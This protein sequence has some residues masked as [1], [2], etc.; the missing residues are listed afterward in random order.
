MIGKLSIL[1]LY[2][3]DNTIFDDLALPQHVYVDENDQEQTEDAIDKQT[4]VDNLLMDLAEIS[5][6]IT[7]P[8]VM[9][10]A[11][12]SWSASCLPVWQA[13]WDTTQYEYNPIWNK[14]G[15][16]TEVEERDL[17]KTTDATETRN[18]T[19]SNDVQ[20][21][22]KTSAFNASTMQP[23]DQVITD[24]DTT[25]GGTIDYDNTVTDG[26]QITRT[27]TEQGNIGVTTTQQM[28][29]EQRDIVNFNI[30][31]VIIDDFKQRFCIM[32][33]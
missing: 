29:K 3:W 28:I 26:G 30:Y 6:I 25:D 8:D 15:T 16:V 22:S 14:D 20:V 2:N 13:L 23:V 24:Q 9:K 1:G 32:V 27:R 11:I 19:G 17:E 4:L 18:L 5:V 10:L 33:Y 21:D 12:K 7:D 31:R